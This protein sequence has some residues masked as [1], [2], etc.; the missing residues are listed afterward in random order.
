MTMG[1]VVTMLTT[2]MKDGQSKKVTSGWRKQNKEETGQACQCYDTGH[3][4]KR[5]CGSFSS[6]M[7][8]C[9]H[10]EAVKARLVDRTALPQHSEGQNKGARQW[11]SAH[12]KRNAV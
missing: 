8:G 12:K 7:S 5:E 11:I 10:P 6:R 9:F 1:Q 2:S 3:I 4:G